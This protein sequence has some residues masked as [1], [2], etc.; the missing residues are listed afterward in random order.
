MSHGQ[1]AFGDRRRAS[2]TAEIPVRHA[3]GAEAVWLLGSKET[4][5]FECVGEDAMAETC[6]FLVLL[7]LLPPLIL[8]REEL[9]FAHGAGVA[10]GLVKPLFKTAAAEDV[11]AG[12][13]NRVGQLGVADWAVVIARPFLLDGNQ[14]VVAIVEE[15]LACVRLLA[16]GI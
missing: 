12:S 6:I 5:D 16:D 8:E 1:R 10:V 9:D 14:P 7:P 13:L 15:S 4:G 3:E 11:L 2:K